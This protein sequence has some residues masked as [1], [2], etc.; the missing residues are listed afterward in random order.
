MLPLYLLQRTLVKLV[1]LSDCRN[2]TVPLPAPLENE[3]Y[4]EPA[5]RDFLGPPY[6]CVGVAEVDAE[7]APWR[8]PSTRDTTDDLPQQIRDHF[9]RVRAGEP[10]PTAMTRH[11]R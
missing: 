6:A 3:E 8:R 5:T 7:R 11:K 10:P 1:F 2:V 4:H 9:T